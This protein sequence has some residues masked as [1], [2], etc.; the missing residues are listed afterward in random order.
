MI[1]EWSCA[2]DL[3]QYHNGQRVLNPLI[4]EYPPKL[5]AS[6]F[7]S[8]PTPSPTHTPTHTTSN[9]TALFV[10]YCFF[11]WMGD[12]ATSDVLFYLKMSHVKPWYLNTRSVFFV[13]IQQDI[14]LTQVLTLLP[15]SYG[16][17]STVS[18]L[19]NHF[20]ELLFTNET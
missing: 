20:K 18:R 12:R 4:Y 5:P 3:L 2:Q 1:P 14:R 8:F 11:G 10:A 6:S 17:V 13:Y 19:Q 16:W 15:L 7:S 9:P